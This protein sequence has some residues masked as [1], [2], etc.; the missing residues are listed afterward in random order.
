MIPGMKG[1]D[2]LIFMDVGTPGHTI[3]LVRVEENIL[4]VEKLVLAVVTLL[5]EEEDASHLH[6]FIV[7]ISE[8]A[9]VMVLDL[10]AEVVTFR[11]AS[12]I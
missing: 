10:V 4:G 5:K 2:L 9:A 12:F 6:V 1:E 8:T 7:N 11:V 3:I